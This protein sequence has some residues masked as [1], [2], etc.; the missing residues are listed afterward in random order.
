MG[1]KASNFAQQYVEVIKAW[2]GKFSQ[3]REDQPGPYVGATVDERGRCRIEVNDSWV[4]TLEP[5]DAVALADWI[6]ETFT[7]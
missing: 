2:P 6:K 4:A 5:R 1:T 7:P 3:N